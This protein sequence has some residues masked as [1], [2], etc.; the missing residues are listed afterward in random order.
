MAVPTHAL[1]PAARAVREIAACAVLLVAIAAGLQLIEGYLPNPLT[2]ALFGAVGVSIVVG[3]LGLEKDAALRLEGRRIAAS[4]TL[5]LLL[6]VIPLLAALATGSR[7]RTG[8]VGLATVLGV[9]QSVA[10]AYRDELWLHGL[11]AF[12][13][14]RA[15]VPLRFVLPY[16]VVTGI[17]P[18]LLDAHATPAGLALVASSSLLFTVLWLRGGGAVVPVVAHLVWRL[19]AEVVFAGDVFDLEPNKLPTGARASG[20]LVWVSAVAM[21]AAA[22]LTWRWAVRLRLRSPA[23]DS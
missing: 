3:Q 1:A 14:R 17:A 21:V 20:T 13:A 12:F 4:A 6:A 16:L 9:A 22:L 10:V 11:P 18:V 8:E 7:I 23:E 19:V 5:G 15:N 2:R